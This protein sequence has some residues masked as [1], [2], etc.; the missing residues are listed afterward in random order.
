MM[1]RSSC[2]AASKWQLEGS[3]NVSSTPV[4]HSAPS[5]GPTAQDLLQKLTLAQTQSH[6]PANQPLLFGGD[7]SGSG[8]IWTM[9]REESQKGTQRASL[10][11]QTQPIASIWTNDRP[12]PPGSHPGTH[13]LPSHSGPHVQ[14]GPQA[15]PQ[16][17]GGNASWPHTPQHM[18]PPPPGLGPP[19]FGP[20]G[21][22]N[23]PPG[24]GAAN[25]S[26]APPV[27]S[28]QLKN[29]HGQQPLSMWGAADR[30]TWGPAQGQQ[31]Q[32]RVPSAQWGYQPQ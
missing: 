19:G 4:V 30:N 27:L 10:P 16:H 5:T 6:G 23:A 26:T 11:A 8:S 3:A 15:L 12:V 7:L 20:P 17:A 2:G 25:W 1:T 29:G 14:H 24:L 28:A 13:P 21:L 31:P 22:A 18:P 9:S 32:G